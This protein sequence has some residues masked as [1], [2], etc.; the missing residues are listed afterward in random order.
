[1]LWKQPL[2]NNVDLFK[3]C[4]SKL[5]QETTLPETNYL[6]EFYER[7]FVAAINVCGSPPAHCLLFVARQS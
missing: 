3:R 1:M 7:N 6:S 5:A 2:N 4:T